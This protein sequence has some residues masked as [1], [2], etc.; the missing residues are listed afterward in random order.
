MNDL[1]I[2]QI[3]EPTSE[4]LPQVERQFAEL[5]NFIKD[6]GLKLP[7]VKDGEKKWIN[8]IKKTVGKFVALFVAVDGE[9]VAGFVSGVV[10]F[11][12]D[13][14]GNQKVGFLTFHYIEPDYRG[15]GIGKKLLK[16]LENWFKEKNV[17]S[18]EVQV[19]FMNEDSRNYFKKNGYEYELVQF[20]KFLINHKSAN[21]IN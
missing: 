4:L 19:S 12:P 15:K 2:I 5:Y 11:T 14:L 8:S 3:K 17:S 20:R 7:L 16:S 6:K 9:K 18:I 13:Y 10:K 1:R 21:K